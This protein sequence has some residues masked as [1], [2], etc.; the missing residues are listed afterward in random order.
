MREFPKTTTLSPNNRAA[1]VS[2]MMALGGGYEPLGGGDMSGTVS[3]YQNYGH[4]IQENNLDV[5]LSHL[6]FQTTFE[7][8]TNNW[9]MP[10]EN[11][12]PW[13][14]QDT[15]FLDR[16]ILDQRAFDIR[17]KLKYTA[18]TQNTPHL[19]TRELL[20]AIELITAD[21]IAGYIKLYF[22]HWHKHAPMV[23][24]PTFNPC[25]AALPIVLALMG[26]G[27]M[28]CTF[29]DIYNVELEALLLMSDSIRKK[30][31]MSPSSNSSWIQ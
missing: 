2:S 27:G 4:M 25:T 28:V 21:N 5:F 6:E 30:V 18:A 20:E 10:G 7:R 1:E 22:R 14:G 8:Q 29:R 31:K 11:I 15:H 16:R 12:I 9:Q 19:P 17:E 26:L 23:H 13:S 3:V 24:E